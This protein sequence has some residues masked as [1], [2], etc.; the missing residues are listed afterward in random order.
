MLLR[1]AIA[2][3]AALAPSVLAVQDLHGQADQQGPAPPP[4]NL[5]ASPIELPRLLDIAAQTLG[6]NLDYDATALKAIGPITLRIPE[7]VSNDQL[8]LLV[9]RVLSARGF[10]TIRTPGPNSYSVVKLGEAAALAPVAESVKS[11]EEFPAGFQNVL[12]RARNRPAR[13]LADVAAKLLSRPSGGGAG[14]GAATVIDGGLVQLSDLTSKL[15][16]VLGLLES[17]DTGA[18]PAGIEEIRLSSLTGPQMVALVNQIA[19][20]RDGSVPAALP[21]GA[22]AAGPSD[23]AGPEVIAGPDPA[24]ILIIAPPERFAALRRLIADLDRRPRAESVTYAPRHF[25]ARDVAR[26]IEQTVRG[27]V[28]AD[29]RFKVVVDD[30]TGSLIITGSPAQHQAVRALVDRLDEAPA[31]AR[32][33]VRSFV[34]K[35]RPVKE[36]QG[37]LEDLLRA[38][39]LDAGADSPTGTSPPGPGPAA[40]ITPMP[41]PPAS[42]SG[43]APS[44]TTA[45]TS[46]STRA[47]ATPPGSTRSTQPVSE[48]HP[49]VLTVDEGTNT[50]IA[51]GDPRV[52]DQVQTLLKTLDVRQAQVM[53]EVLM[54]TLSEGETLDLGVELESITMSGDLRIRLSSLFGLGIRGAGGDRDGPG[55]ANGFTGVV[56][57]P[58]EFSVIVRALQTLNSGRSLSMPRLLVSN[59]QS[60]SF[61]SVVQQPFASV[62]ASNTVSTTS[63]GGTQDAGTVVTIKPQIAE[64]DH[65]LL[66]YSVSL[67]AF[68][69]AASSPTLPPPR[70]Q[71]RVQSVA[72]I[73]DGFTVV[74][75]G[76]EVQN[77]ASTTAQVPVIGSIPLLGELFKNR[78]KLQNRSKFFVFVRP[79]I[80][81]HQGFEDLKY[82]SEQAT[83]AVM[84]DDGFPDVEP[85]II[86]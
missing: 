41:P 65:L 8:W 55:S 32:R 35:N 13:E 70:Q 72:T 2:L 15:Q 74:V 28:P 45:A 79:T 85:R 86:P 53:L 34:I 71:N 66:D 67:S 27:G 43:S 80:L 26:L 73:P 7:G 42:S 30:L 5:L 46:V 31:S 10:T 48:E 25:A 37:I 61:D 81:R 40:V 3:A 33:P 22:A 19:G 69:G 9:N 44:V 52:L 11:K 50:L 57:S 38:G 77:Q 36:I 21:A 47:A 83:G 16:E 39:V 60:A 29:D 78:N 14:G 62:N 84:L 1:C 24:S 54:L 59:N 75:G 20:K 82:A 23:R 18:D 6:L 49:L 17:L 51:M 4:V 63:F 12:Y 76:I 58:G 68:L 64:G 56:L